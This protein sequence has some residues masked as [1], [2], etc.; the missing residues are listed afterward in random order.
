MKRL[1]LISLLSL[2]TANLF[3]AN[4]FAAN[5]AGESSELSRA[6][7]ALS[8]AAG[9]VVLGSM[10]AVAA[11]GYVVIASVETLAD[12]SVIVL[13]GASDAA[14]ATVKLSAKAAE[15]LSRAVGQAVT[16]T[17]ISTG[18]VLVMSGQAI[19]FIPNEVGQALIHH[20]RVGQ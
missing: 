15:G 17:A 4:A 2:A 9:M 6:S 1:L 20:S 5:G 3:A 19:A 13:K 16:V 7:E 12:G 11:S 14:T 8:G 10:S 18:Y